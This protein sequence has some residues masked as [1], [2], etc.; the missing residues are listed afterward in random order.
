MLRQ[1]YRQLPPEHCA[2]HSMMWPATMPAASRSQSSARP[3]ELVAQRRHRERGVGRAP[4]DDDVRAARERLDDRRRADVRVGRQH[5]VAHRGERLARLHV[6]E[7]VAAAISS[8]SRGSRSSPVTTP[9][10]T[11]AGHAA[12]P[13]HRA[14]RLGAG[15]RIHAAGV[16][17]DAHAAL[18][19]RR[20]A[21][22]RSRRR[23]RARSPSSGSRSFCFCRMRHRDFGEVVEHQVVDR[24]RPRPGGAAPRA[25]RP[26]NPVPR[27]ANDAIASRLS[28]AHASS[29]CARQRR[30]ARGAARGSAATRGAPC[31]STSRV[32]SG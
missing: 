1:S 21:R 15:R 19:D 11:C 22:S 31:A 25:N 20:R 32:S 12:L 24:R 3:A 14:H 9:M 29:K 17:D 18:G 2:P 5:A 10:R 7:R 4:G 26:R 30:T 28:C 27:D 8:S 13:R 6:R 23:S 16:G